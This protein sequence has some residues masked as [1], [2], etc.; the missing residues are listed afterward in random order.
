MVQPREPRAARDH[1]HQV[2]SCLFYSHCIESVFPC[3]QEGF[4]LSYAKQR[5]E[6]IDKIR[7]PFVGRNARN[8]AHSTEECFKGKLLD[9]V[10]SYVSAALHPDPHTCLD[11]ETEAIAMMNDCYIEGYRGEM[12]E[13]VPGVDLA[14]VVDLFRVEPAYHNL[15]VDR[16]LVEHIR[17]KKGKPLANSL[18]SNHTLSMP[19]RILLCIKG[20]KYPHGI[21]GEE[22]D[23]TPED[24]ITI[25]KSALQEYDD[26]SSE[27]YYGGPDD[28]D[29][30]CIARSHDKDLVG[31]FNTNND[32]YHLV[33]WF[34][35]NTI[36]HVISR[37]AF[38]DAD[39][40][41]YPT[42][43]ELTSLE[44]NFSRQQTRCGD[45]RRQQGESCDFTNNYPGCSLDC[46][47]MESYDCTVGKLE[48][49]ECWLEQCGDGVRTR[50]ENCDDGNINST[51]GCSSTCKIEHLT[52]TC[53]RDY[54]KT[55]ECVSMVPL[56]EQVQP[57]SAK[58]LSQATS[59]VTA[60][61]APASSHSQEHTSVE[62]TSMELTK[63]TVQP[64]AFVS[65]ASKSQSTWSYLVA[66]L[67][68]LAF[69][70]R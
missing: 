51:D 70:L 45:G 56:Q 42:I 17:T 9:L 24:F 69:V 33:T 37:S 11:F 7:R 40:M 36:E 60:R 28:I 38:Y 58:L 49:S 1:C 62:H 4:V 50:S 43:F 59:H 39:T 34:T 22:I 19:T 65:G 31:D 2:H 14:K 5:C 64:A 32:Y 20:S 21:H 67:L 61:H 23:P 52:H 68:G 44:G 18:L 66:A 3:G 6:E 12:L 41:V 10:D 63:R 57:A 29:D 54:N 30:L 25:L 46:Q 8:W 35:T 13:N 15:T 27:F 53:T 16:G 26:G 48:P 47:P 55:S